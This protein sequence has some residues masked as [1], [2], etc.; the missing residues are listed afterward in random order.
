MIRRPRWRD[1]SL[2]YRQT[3][4]LSCPIASYYCVCVSVCHHLLSVCLSVSLFGW[5]LYYY[6]YYYTYHYHYYY[7]Y[8]YYC[9][10][11]YYTYCY[12][13]AWILS[14]HLGRARAWRRRCV[15]CSRWPRPGQRPGGGS[16]PCDDSRPHVTT[17][18]RPT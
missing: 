18:R 14:R 17:C 2:S 6:Y 15:P 4:L 8:Y 11:Y 7:T 1:H 10:C 13:S 5:N 9:Y 12:C 16:S 3:T